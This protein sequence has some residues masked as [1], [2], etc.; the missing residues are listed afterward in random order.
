MHCDT[1]VG[2]FMG[3]RVGSGVSVGAG[4]SNPPQPDNARPS[5][6]TPQILRKSRLDNRVIF[7][8]GFVLASKYIPIDHRARKCS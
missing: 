7:F 2:V 8:I 5:D 1:G 6:E 4:V 3:M